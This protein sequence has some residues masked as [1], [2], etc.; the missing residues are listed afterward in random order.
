MTK[1]QHFEGKNKP[2]ESSSKQ[3]TG[4][5]SEGSLI[6]NLLHFNKERIEKG[7]NTSI[8]T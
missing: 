5:S 4:S 8:C 7:L 2:S 3:T 1:T 6:F